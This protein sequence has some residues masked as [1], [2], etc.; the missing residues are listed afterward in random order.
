[1]SCRLASLTRGVA[2]GFMVVV[3]ILAGGCAG[4]PSS[5]LR[6]DELDDAPPVWPPPPERPRYRYMGQLTGE[7]NYRGQRTAVGRKVLAWLVG[8]ATGP[9]SPRVLQRPQGGYT[10]A[11]GRIYVSDVSR[12]AVYVFD[13]KDGLQI[14]EEA[15]ANLHFLTPLGVTAGEPGYILVADADLRRVVIL[16]EQGK[17]QGSMGEGVLQRPVGVA[18]DPV[19]GLIYVADSK[20][21]DVKVFDRDGVLVATWGRRGHGPGEFNAPTYLTF[22]DGRLYVTDTLNSRVQVFDREGRFVRSVGRRGLYLGDLPR[23]KGVA[24]DQDRNLY[25][26]ESYYD[27]LLI[28]NEKGEF[29]LP[30]GGTGNG[31][32]QFYLPAGVWTDHRGWVYVADAFNGRVMIF[33][34][35]RD[36]GES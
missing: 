26:V 27:H 21:H 28:F 22:A 1:M 23:P 29:L 12:A 11:R 5:A 25:V 17:P 13:P 18:R 15:G 32:G 16:N 3:L 31:I 8:L 10:D 36:W 30:I 14:W 35:L 9:H 34:Y 19:S 6:F 7:E 33:E 2:A 20:A 4:G 24:V